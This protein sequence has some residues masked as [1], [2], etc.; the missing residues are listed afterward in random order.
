ME[1]SCVKQE[2]G[3]GRHH[4]SHAKFQASDPVAVLSQNAP[5]PPLSKGP[6]LRRMTKERL[7]FAE[8]SRRSCCNGWRLGKL[9]H[10]PNTNHR[11]KSLRER[12]GVIIEYIVV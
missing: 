11:T 2:F 12:S 10:A 5:S 6:S 1:L 9:A 4:T 8:K 3:L 7:N